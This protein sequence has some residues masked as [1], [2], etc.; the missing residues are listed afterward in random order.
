[1]S[2]R[3]VRILGIAGSLR[4]KSYNRAALRAAAELAPEG[5]SVEIFDL[6][7]IP[8]FS[9][10]TEGQPPAQVIELKRRIREADAVLFA[11]PEYNYSIP[12]V[13]KNAIDWASRP[14]GDNSFDGKP[15]AIMGASVGALGTARAQYHLRQV[16]VFLNMF[17]VNQPEV[18]IGNASQRFDADGNLTDEKTREFIGKLLQS[19][20]AWTRRIGQ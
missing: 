8:P 1:M 5:A 9:E 2:S 10:D 3:P 20:V 19:L 6:D 13:L 17:P 11:T 14:Y 12:G 15:A 18:M 7:G 4:Q 16:M